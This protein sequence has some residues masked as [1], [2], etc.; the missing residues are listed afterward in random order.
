VEFKV[1]LALLVPPVL[2]VPME[3]LEF[4]EQLVYLVKMEQLVFV[5]RLVQKVQLV[6][7]EILVYV[8]KKEIPV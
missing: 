5:E 8:D 3:I 4:E 2:L 1:L 7:L 6:I